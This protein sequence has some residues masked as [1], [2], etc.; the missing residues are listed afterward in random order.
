M[1]VWENISSTVCCNFF[2]G[3]YLEETL[4][5]LFLSASSPCGSYHRRLYRSQVTS[6]DHSFGRKSEE[7]AEEVSWCGMNVVKMW[8]YFRKPGIREVNV[9]VLCHPW[10]WVGTHW[11]CFVNTIAFP[12]HCI[13]S[14]FEPI[15]LHCQRI[16]FCCQTVV[17]HCQGILFHSQCVIFS[18]WFHYFKTN[19]ISFFMRDAMKDA[20]TFS[21]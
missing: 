21:T 2:P 6:I 5:S 13:V 16:V 10:K 14:Q 20:K 9:N 18:F 11:Q 15:V 12:G 7:S 8:P 4:S 17:D 19:W 1:E 3:N